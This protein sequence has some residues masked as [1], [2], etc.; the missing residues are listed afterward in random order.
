MTDLLTANFADH[1]VVDPVAEL[2]GAAD[3]SIVAGKIASVTWRDGEAAALETEIERRR[4]CHA[5]RRP[6]PQAGDRSRR[7]EE[8]LTRLRAFVRF[9]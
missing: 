8:F 2:A 5:S 7:T 3:V 4:R 1:W 6:V 9:A